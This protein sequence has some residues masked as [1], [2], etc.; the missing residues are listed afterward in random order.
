M[1][2]IVLYLMFQLLYLSVYGQA[3]TTD[4]FGNCDP[5][6]STAMYPKSEIRAVWL[7]T[8]M[9]LDWPRT[10]AHDES[11]IEA[12]KS[13]FRQILD[14]LEAAHINTV[15]LQTRIRG[16][17]IYPSNI[18]PFDECLTGT[19]GKHPGSDPLYFAINE[20]HRR[21]MEL[22][23]WLVTIPLGDKKKQSGYGSKSVTQTRPELCKSAGD[24]WFMRPD[25]SGTGDYMAMI[26]RELCE[27]YDIDGIS[28]DYIR[29]PEKSYNYSDNLSASE[30]RRAIT[31]IVKKIH[32]V[33]K[34]IKPWVKL[35]SSPIGKFKDLSRY[36]SR[37][38]NSYDAVYQDAQGWLR[39]NLQDMLFPM[40][41][42]RGDNFFPFMYDWVEHQYGH[43][44]APGLGIYFLDPKEGNWE[45]DDVRHQ[46]HAARNSGIGGVVLYRSDFF[47]RNCQGLYDSAIREFFP[48]PS[49]PS[50]MTWSI[51]TVSPSRPGDLYHDVEGSCLYWIGSDDHGDR[52][53]KLND[54]DYVYYNIYGSDIYPVDVSSSKHLLKSRVTGSFFRLPPSL[55]HYKY[56]AMTACDRFGN[57]SAAAQEY[58]M[59][60]LRDLR[61]IWNPRSR[62]A[63]DGSKI[64]DRRTAPSSEPESS[65]KSKK[66]GRR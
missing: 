52:E 5:W 17:L 30:R 37:G 9:S 1:R 65:S 25:A 34:P 20:C 60:M 58:Q 45:L 56:Y 10:K 55:S 13:E 64:D 57:E 38:W 4:E 53:L 33:V 43:P 59:E 12:Q 40:M 36:S 62:L 28:L 50:R 7:A 8:I 46:I 44:V 6:T 32:D 16:S 54:H 21:G 19:P 51:D 48:T 3:Y 24:N 29:Y 27:R 18:E 61:P 42:F 11:S 41:Y 22:H 47:T 31:S 23:C 35:S 66:K 2:K 26:C 39:D 63:S 49:L 15:V 14:K